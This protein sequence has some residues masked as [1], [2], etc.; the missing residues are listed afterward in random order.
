MSIEKKE[1][2]KNAW[3]KY[4]GKEVEEVFDFCEGYR[5]FMSKCKTERECVKEVI[6]L[7]KA[8]GYKDIE[9]IIKK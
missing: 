8:E 6:R 3:N 7:A 5:K 9:D 4:N 1:S 2:S